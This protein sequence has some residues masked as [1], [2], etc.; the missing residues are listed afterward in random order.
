MKI[1]FNLI[2]VITVLIVCISYTFSQLTSVPSS[3]TS[4][5]PEA[6]QYKVVYDLTIPTASG[7]I[8]YAQ[9]NSNTSGVVYNK[10]AYFMQLDSKWVWVSMDKFNSS[11]TLAQLAIPV[12]NS[13]IVFQ[14]IVTGMN[15]TTSGNTGITNV[16]NGNGNIE[17]WPYCYGTSNGLSGIG[18]DIS[19]YDF[20]DLMDVNLNQCYGSFQ[21]HNY[22]ASQTLF[23]FNNF[24]S[25]GQT[26]DLG[27]GN[28]SGVASNGQSNPDWTFM[29]NSP[30]YST[31]KLYILVD[32]CSEITITAHPN[33][34]A[35]NLFQ[36][37]SGNTL[38]VAATTTF[39]SIN[40]YQWY[41]NNVA[42]NTNGTLI[43]GA[44]ALTYTIPTSS[45]GSNYYYCK[46]GNS[47]G[48]S[49]TTNVSGLV[50][51]DPYVWTGSISNALTT[52]SNWNSGTLPPNGSS[53][54][55]SASAAN[56][57]VLDGNRTYGTINFNG[58]NKKIELGNFNLTATSIIGVNASNYVKTIGTGKLE[59]TLANNTTAV[60]PVG[61]SSYNPLTITNKSGT[62][63]VFSVRVIDGAYMEGL[64]GTAITSTVLNRTWD[65]SK[66]NANAGSGIDFVFNWNANEVVNGSFS[67]PK[68]NHYSSSTTNWEVPTVTSTVFG[69]NMLTVTGYTGTFSPFTIAEGT[70]ALPTELT[71]FNAN[72]TE[73]GTTINWQ[74][75]SEHNSASFDV[76][77]SRDGIN[78]SVA[79]TIVAGGNSAATID[80]SILD[81]EKA[82]GVVYYRLNQIDLDG[83]SKIYGPISATCFETTD[84]TATVFP[85]PASGM[86]TLELD[87]PT[88][89]TVSIQ[90]CGT[91]GKVIEQ[92][93]NTLEEGTTQIPLSIETLN[94][95]VY[96]LK[97][98][99]EN[100]IKT[101]KLIVQ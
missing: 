77:K 67:S 89:Q 99:V 48:C 46:I 6:S 39:G 12:L 86:V 20:N 5:V 7:T 43:S 63:D 97:V 98:N 79:E 45:I 24:V 29:G 36:N 64:T 93:A 35:L 72:C 94:V 58:S 19:K 96:T 44:T 40:S 80:Y 37:T 4:L 66:T 78:W 41:A 8:T 21:V 100:E 30:N 17:F 9:N 13:G 76:E 101:I 34:S 83:A 75:A 26:P 23:A 54:S 10:V 50:K 56:N 22:N 85:N 70:S 62:S 3:I 69:S 74:T 18:G 31:R 91:D 11:L 38:S 82:T 57:L 90:I 61:N 47:N 60:Y 42:S 33:N 27:I 59:M 73:I 51:V 28:N 95:G 92:I 68:M 65:I 2:Q 14:Q 15:V 52:T 71:A 88:A 32:A 81:T 1:I 25:A 87:V 16:T 84:F 49:V 55:F 53:I